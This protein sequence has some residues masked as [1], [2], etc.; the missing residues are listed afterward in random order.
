MQYNTI[1]DKRWNARR[2]EKCNIKE[3]NI[4]TQMYE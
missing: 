1:A 3:F 4:N 2:L